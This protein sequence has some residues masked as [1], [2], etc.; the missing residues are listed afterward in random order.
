[1]TVAPGVVV[2]KYCSRFAVLSRTVF[3]IN[4]VLAR[5]AGEADTRTVPAARSA[6]R[7]VR[8]SSSVAVSRSWVE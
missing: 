1:V 7:I 2:G 4:V 3:G 6:V 5:L 8:M